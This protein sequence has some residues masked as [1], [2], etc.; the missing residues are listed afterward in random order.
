VI[1][2]KIIF[3][4]VSIS[5]SGIGLMIPIIRIKTHLEFFTKNLQSSYQ[6][7]SF[8]SIPLAIVLTLFYA[9]N[10]KEFNSN[11]VGMI[12]NKT[13]KNRIIFATIACALFSIFM[14]FITVLQTTMC[15]WSINEI[16]FIQ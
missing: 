9:L 11:K 5:F 6:N 2:S 8:L 1:T 13:N 12:D 7:F 16:L 14:M 4:W 3:R 15:S 10:K